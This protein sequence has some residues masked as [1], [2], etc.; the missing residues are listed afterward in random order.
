MAIVS[1]FIQQ[2]TS[3]TWRCHPLGHL[4]RNSR[5]QASRRRRY[6]Q[7]G[8]HRSSQWLSWGLQR[9][10]LRRGRRQGRSQHEKAPRRTW[11]P[12]EGHFQEAENCV[13]V[14]LKNLLE[15]WEN[16]I[17]NML[18]FSEPAEQVWTMLSRWMFSSMTSTT[19]THSTR[20][21]RSF[22]G[23]ESTTVVLFSFNIADLSCTI[24]TIK[25][26]ACAVWE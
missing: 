22:S 7:P 13:E 10:V 24:A 23:W 4:P 6:Y 15:S 5:W 3:T 20:C 12:T 25:L 2:Y 8:Y 11:R 21:T 17:F 9:N 16:R 1:Y 14:R 19:T 26:N 18:N